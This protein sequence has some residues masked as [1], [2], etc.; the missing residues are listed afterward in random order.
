MGSV[1]EQAQARL[2]SM[3]QRYTPGRESIVNAL[4]DSGR[5]LTIAE[6]LAAQPPA[7]QSSVY[8]NLTV[9]EMAGVVR[10]IQGEDEF[11]RFE[12]AE[13]LTTHHHHLLCETC[14]RVTD[15]TLPPAV[16]RVVGKAIAEVGHQ[17]GF[18]PRAHRLDLVGQCASCA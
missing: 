3:R 12:L 6:L 9:L 8:R 4:T 1:H 2:R 16:E 18:R 7:A 17:T 5:P 14:G 15:Y 11:F 10:R 13:D